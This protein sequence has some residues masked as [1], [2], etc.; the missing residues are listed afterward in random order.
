MWNIFTSQ[1]TSSC[2][3]FKHSTGFNNNFS[4][5]DLKRQTIW[6][7]Q[8]LCDVRRYVRR[9]KVKCLC[10]SWV[11]RGQMPGFWLTA[12]SPESWGVPVVR[13]HGAPAESDIKGLQSL[14]LICQLPA[15]STC[16]SPLPRWARD[17]TQEGSGG[18]M[19]REVEEDLC[20]CWCLCDEL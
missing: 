10:M 15:V 16:L 14:L 8:Y 13:R 1:E 19:S 6:P 7:E 3:L 17:H 2:L 4:T 11:R 5:V 12:A 18:E 20:L 9:E